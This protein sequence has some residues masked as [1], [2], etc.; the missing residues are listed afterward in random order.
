MSDKEIIKE[1]IRLIN[2]LNI[3]IEEKENFIK[4]IMKE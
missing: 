1:I 2:I 3:S 4:E